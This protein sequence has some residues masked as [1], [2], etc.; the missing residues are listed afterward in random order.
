MQ[1]CVEACE[2]CRADVAGSSS[3]ESSGCGAGCGG[4]RT[5][6]STDSILP[7]LLVLLLRSWKLSSVI[8]ETSILQRAALAAH[9]MTQSFHCA[10]Q[11][12]AVKMKALRVES[13]ETKN[14]VCEIAI[15]TL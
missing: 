4:D 3:G 5:E 7:P 14:D 8:L 1:P 13:N 9:K 6:V 15:G 11:Q 12:N 10:R 2:S